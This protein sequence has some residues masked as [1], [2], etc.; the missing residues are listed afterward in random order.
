[1][2]VRIGPTYTTYFANELWRHNVSRSTKSD[3]INFDSNDNFQRNMFIYCN[4]S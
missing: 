4:H 2:K 3:V 1:V